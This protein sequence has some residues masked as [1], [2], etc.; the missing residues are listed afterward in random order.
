MIGAALLWAVSV[1]LELMDIAAPN[2]FP[3]SSSTLNHILG[4]PTGALISSPPHL[5][6]RP[7][8]GSCAEA[9]RT[10]ASASV[11]PAGSR[12]AHHAEGT[13]AAQV[14][15]PSG[16]RWHSALAR[17]VGPL[18]LPPQPTKPAS[19]TLPVL[20]LRRVLAHGS[21]TRTL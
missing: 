19:Y 6:V 15:W 20:E 9:H 2:M 13:R 12:G 16:R 14:D 21:G 17:V 11:Y 18:A 7:A 5:T 3:T 4:A 8:A 1:P 10:V